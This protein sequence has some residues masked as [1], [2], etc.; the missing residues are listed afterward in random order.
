MPEEVVNTK[1]RP[2]TELEII[3]KISRLAPGLTAKGIVYVIEMLN[4]MARQEE[5]G[6]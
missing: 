4:D 5:L 6:I 1:K 3:N 2:L